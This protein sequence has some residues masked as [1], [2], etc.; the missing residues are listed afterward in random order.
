MH[1]RKEAGLPAVLNLNCLAE[2]L[3]REAIAARLEIGVASVYR[4]LG[5][6]DAAEAAGGL[7]AEK[8]APSPRR[9]SLASHLPAG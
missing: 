7:S 1:R 5:L 4:A 9:I 6:R 2:G 8:V 3:T